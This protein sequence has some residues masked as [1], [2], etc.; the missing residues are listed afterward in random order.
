MDL[1][2]NKEFINGFI[3]GGYKPN[4]KIKKV[5]EYIENLDIWKDDVILKEIIETIERILK[6]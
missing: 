1:K 4:L 6:K 5:L 2:T 3:Q